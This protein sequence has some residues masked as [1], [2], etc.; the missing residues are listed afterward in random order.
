MIERGGFTRQCASWRDTVFRLCA[1]SEPIVNSVD[2]LASSDSADIRTNQ[3]DHT[4]KLVPQNNGKWPRL[5]RLQIECRKPLKLG[6]RDG[7]RMDTDHYLPFVR[8]QSRDFS[9]D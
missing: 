8:V 7:T 2:F 4:R 9:Q 1:V 5:T 6:R 3:L